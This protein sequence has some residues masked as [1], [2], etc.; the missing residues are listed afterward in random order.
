MGSNFFPVWLMVGTK[1]VR[2]ERKL[3]LNYLK[4]YL[5]KKKSYSDCWFDRFEIN[6]PMK[7]SWLHI[8]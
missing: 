7:R 5:S 4:K 6:F 8:L 1:M 2:D 3:I